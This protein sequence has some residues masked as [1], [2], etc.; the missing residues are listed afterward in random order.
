MKTFKTYLNEASKAGI[1]THMVHIEDQIFYGGVNGARDAII[2]LRSMRDM[3]AG[4]S[5]RAVDTSVKFDGAPAVFAGIDP[6]DGQFFVAKKGIFNKNPKLYKSIDDVKA[7]T[8]GDLQRKLIIAFEELSKLGINGIIQGDI[9]FTREDLKEEEIDGEK[10]ITFHPNT[11]VYAVPAKSPEAKIIQKAKIGVAWHTTYVGTSLDS[12]T[13]KF[14][15]DISKLK[16][17]PNVWQQDAMV[18]DLSG[19]VTLL[20]KDTDEITKKLSTAGKLFQ[21]ISSSTLKEIESNPAFAGM[22]ETFNNSFVRKGQKIINTSKHVD[23]LINWINEKYAKEAD[24][25]KTE[26]GKAA[27]IGKRDEILK[28]FS[29]KNKKNLKNA[30]DL[31]ILIQEIKEVIIEKLQEVGELKTF[32]KTKNGFKIT[33]QEGY[34]VIDH[35][36]NNAVK[37][38]KRLQFAHAN[39]SP[40]I[41]KGWDH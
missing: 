39:F 3:L 15:V 23:N 17:N 25:R 19:K 26:K 29:Q 31:Y 22:I 11:I 41:I 33:G 16:K 28:F 4:N 35:L 21:K 30:F 13:A 6:S 40:N 37:L 32:L 18:R 8:S 27:V 10:Y 24:K 1:N 38:V 9:M 7:D 20:K 34:V 2:A 12:L 5:T 36:S 14:G